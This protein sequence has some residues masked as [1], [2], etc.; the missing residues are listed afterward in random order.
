MP[1][2]NQILTVDKTI[3]LGGITGVSNYIMEDKSWCEVYRPKNNLQ[4]YHFMHL[5]LWRW[6]SIDKL[7]T[8]CVYTSCSNIG[9]YKLNRGILITEPRLPWWLMTDVLLSFLKLFEHTKNTFTSFF[10]V[11]HPYIKGCCPGQLAKVVMKGSSLR[12]AYTCEV[13]GQDTPWEAAT[14]CRLHSVCILLNNDEIAQPVSF[15]LN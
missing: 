15:R 7:L 13:K 3:A 14:F 6:F 9:K 12:E 10:T 8:I 4:Q 1:T 11:L 5:L 2:S